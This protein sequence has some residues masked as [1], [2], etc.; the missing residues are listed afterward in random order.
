[1]PTV[2]AL[3]TE[4]PPPD[5]VDSLALFQG[6]WNGL[7]FGEGTN[8]AVEADIDGLLAYES[9]LADQ[10][11]PG[12]D[13]DISFARYA[14]GRFVVLAF[15]I[16]GPPLSA[17]LTERIAQWYTAFDASDPYALDWLLFR[18]PGRVLL[19]RARVARR[20]IEVAP[21]S[22]K[23]GL[24]RAVVELKVA[25]PR[26]YDGSSG[27]RESMLIP[28]GPAVGGGFEL[29]VEELPLDMSAS[30]GG[31]AIAVNSGNAA[32]SPILRI[33]NAGPGNVTQVVVS[34]LTAGITCT[35]NSVIL[36]GQTLVADFEALAR[37]EAGPYVHIDGVSRYSEW[38]HPRIPLVLLPGENTLV[39]DFTGGKPTVRIDWLNTNL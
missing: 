31:S 14:A 12:G 7:V 27:G 38:A 37:H 28:T 22:S 35:F 36:P 23:S 17:E 21:L 3:R 1:M 29:A 9:R 19:L 18:V 34:N 4:P 20:R 11:V 6:Y 24:T 15:G 16:V 30:T 26:L 39:A 32:A 8:F 33:S 2:S 13:G 25:D 5:V 10:P